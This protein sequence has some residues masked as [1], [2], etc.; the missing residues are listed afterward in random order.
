MNTHPPIVV[1][2]YK[3]PEELRR[4]L[5]SLE[6]NSGANNHKLYII[7]DGPKSDED[8]DLVKECQLVASEI[9]NFEEVLVSKSSSNSGLS[10]S[11]KKGLQDIFVTHERAIIVEDDLVLHTKFLEFMS[12]GLMVYAK[13]LTVASVQGFSL[14]EREDGNAYFLPGAD[15]WGWATW[16]DRWNRVTWDSKFNLEKIKSS[17]LEKSFNYENSYNFTKLLE[18][19]TQEKIDSWAIDWQASMFLQRRLSLYPPFNL[20]QN[21]GEGSSSTNTKTISKGLPVLSGKSDWYMPTEVTVIPV[22]YASVVMAYSRFIQKNRFIRTVLR[23][24]K[25][26]YSI[27]T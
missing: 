10:N 24:I 26:I 1:F 16:R 27:Q 2:A 14:I 19:N 8:K 12:Q 22:I 5:E 21:E 23:K 11:I 6:S 9:W 13:D 7:I 3:R 4:C 20:V 18:L 25:A 17:N 15:C